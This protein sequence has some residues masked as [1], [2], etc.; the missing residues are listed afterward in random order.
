MHTP[1][2]RTPAE[3]RFAEVFD[4][5]PA[6]VAYARRRGSAD[7]EALAAETMATAWRRLA[8]VPRDEP[9]PWLLATARNLLWAEWRRASRRRPPDTP[10]VPDEAL[11]NGIDPD[12]ER[13]LLS[14]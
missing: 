9:R 5:L 11:A 10:A 4:H 3:T 1:S 12:L 13:A 14:L 6:V 8:D 2:D 7:P